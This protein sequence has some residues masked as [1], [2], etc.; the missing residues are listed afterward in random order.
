[1]TLCCA[2]LY[3]AESEWSGAPDVPTFAHERRLAMSFPTEWAKFVPKP[4]PLTGGD[5][6]HVLLSYRSVNRAWV[7]NLYDVLRA[8]GHEVFLDQ[9]VLKVC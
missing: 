9:C 1:L 6:Y 8:H 4:R 3:K 7:L 2:S 5:E